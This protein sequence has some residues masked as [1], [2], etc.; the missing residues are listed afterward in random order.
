MQSVFILDRTWRDERGLP[1][2]NGCPTARQRRQNI[3]LLGIVALCLGT[4]GGPRGLGVSYERGTPVPGEM[5]AA[6]PSPIAVRLRERDDNT[7]P[8]VTCRVV[9]SVH[10]LSAISAGTW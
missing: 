3:G 10:Q 8:G 4:Y 1:L 6:S 7:L 5:S 9:L 2:S